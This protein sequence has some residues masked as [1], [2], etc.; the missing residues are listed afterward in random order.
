M[1]SR[2]NIRIKVM[3]ILYSISRDEKL[4]LESAIERYRRSIRKS[5]ELYLFNLYAFT[6]ILEY[7]RQ[8]LAKRESKYLPS[9]EDQQFKAKIA[10]NELS[11][12]L[13]KNDGFIRLI[14]KYDFEKALDADTIRMVY[15]E[16]AKTEEYKAYILQS[17]V[18]EDDHKNLLLALYKHCMGNETFE[19]KMEDYSPQW[20]VD[21]SLV[22]GAIKKT[23]KALPAT[24]LFY[25]N[26]RPS[27]ETTID[28]G[29]KL[30]RQVAE[31]DKELLNIIE[32]SLKNWDAERVAIIDMIL[33]KMALCE[34][35]H[36]PTIPSKVTLN[37]FVDISKMYSTDKS[38]DFINGILD[39]L[40]KKLHKEGKI[41]K[42][43]RGLID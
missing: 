17:E 27:I 28:F 19:E 38:K 21:K 24:P 12:S 30:L 10:T 26:F 4:E 1:L 8:D 36:F 18:T 32:P 15:A 41:N 34:L 13:I 35:L 2:R 39:R 40:M 9:E 3:Q 6:R 25:E 16:F 42:E 14:K 23:L 29:E 20:A 7:A 5:F 43:G 31:T 22:V 37:E 11:L 33:L